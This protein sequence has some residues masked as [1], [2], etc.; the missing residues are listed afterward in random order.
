MIVAR[1]LKEPAAI[2]SASRSATT[3]Q[4][5]NL[6][7]K[8]NVEQRQVTDPSLDLKA[9]PDRPNVHRSQGQLGPDNARERGWQVH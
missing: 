1:R 9:H 6:L 3:S 2:M 8:A 5:L 4:P 7:S